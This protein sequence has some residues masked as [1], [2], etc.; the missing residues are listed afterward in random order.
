[1]EPTFVCLDTSQ[2]MEWLS[3]CSFREQ[4]T[5]HHDPARQKYGQP[6]LITIEHTRSSI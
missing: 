2:L 1:M 5:T 4:L 6:P 3:Y